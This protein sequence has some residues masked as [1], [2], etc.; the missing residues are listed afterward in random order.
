MSSINSEHCEDFPQIF[1]ERR[2]ALGLSKT[3]IAEALEVT[4]SAVRHWEN[5]VH[6]PPKRR[7]SLLAKLLKMPE[8]E[9]KGEKPLSVETLAAMAFDVSA[10]LASLE[11]LISDAEQI[12]SD[13]RALQRRQKPRTRSKRKK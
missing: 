2:L 1:Y 5:G 3:D 7:L 11:A 10:F 9:L 6:R 8:S 12:A 4:E 13:L